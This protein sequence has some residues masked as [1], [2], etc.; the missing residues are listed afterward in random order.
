MFTKKSEEPRILILCLGRRE[1]GLDLHIPM[2]ANSLDLSVVESRAILQKAVSALSD[3]PS[4][5]IRERIKASV[6][7]RELVDDS[8]MNQLFKELE[9]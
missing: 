1:T 2:I 5:E 3:G 8:I 6:T 4:L 7:K 9:E